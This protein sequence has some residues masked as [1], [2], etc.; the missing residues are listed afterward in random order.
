MP[1]R[2]RIEALDKRII[3]ATGVEV[4]Q[5]LLVCTQQREGQTLGANEVSRRMAVFLK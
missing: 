3:E 1:G 2:Q 4:M 5:R